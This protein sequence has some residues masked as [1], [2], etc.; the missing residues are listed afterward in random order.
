MRTL[1]YVRSVRHTL[2]SNRLRAALT[3][4]GTIIGAASIVLLAGLLRSGE[5]MLVSSSQRAS[6]SDLI[7]VTTE[8]S[9]LNSS[10]HQRRELGWLDKELVEGSEVLGGARVAMSS[11]KEFSAEPL[12]NEGGMPT[13][14]KDFKVRMV[15]FAP[16]ELGL[17]RLKIDSGR[18]LSSDDMAEHL[19]VC[20]VGS[21]VWRRL[22]GEG[23]KLVDQRLRIDGHQWV[24]VGIMKSKPML[25]GGGE[26]T[27]M[28]NR[29]VLIPQSTYDSMF[30]PDR[31]VD[32]MYVRLKQ[33]PGLSKKL[34]IAQ[35]LLKQMLERTHN[36]SNF[37]IENQNS[38]EGQEQLILSIIKGLLLST[39]LLSLFVGGI[40]IMNIMLVT[41]TERTREIGVRRAIGA[42]PRQVWTQ[43]LLEAVFIAGVGGIMGVAGGVG[44]TWLVAHALSSGD[45]TF[46]F[47]VETWSVALGLGLSVVTGVVFG[48]FP[49]IRASRMNPVEALRFE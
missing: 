19:R 26:G 17:Y 36:V 49:A 5:D 38:S 8:Q 20:V 2:Q 40:N 25:G 14:E 31:T 3:L 6:E 1:D 46:A 27:W 37:H 7:K 35:Q 12:N 22:F 47:H 48:L 13:D 24:I 15:S 28:W 42:T 9:T 18:E 30:R 10:D 41:V 33:S 44:L 4:L 39:A 43:F 32:V 16:G 21:E 29:K 11:S 23:T 45:G 34:A